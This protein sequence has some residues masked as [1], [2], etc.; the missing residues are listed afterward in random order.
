MTP[1]P[2]RPVIHPAVWS[3]TLLML[4]A[5]PL[6][7]AQPLMH[8]TDVTV[9][10]IYERP[11]SDE[12]HVGDLGGTWQQADRFGIETI[13]A[14]QFASRVVPRGGFHVALDDRK[15][16]VDGGGTVDGHALVTALTGGAEGR[17]FDGPRRA[18]DPRLGLLGRAGVG[19]QDGTMT[20]I[21][22]ANGPASGDLAPL[23][24]EFAVL[25][26]GRMETTFGLE[27]MAGLGTTWWFANRSTSLDIDN[28]G[29]TGATA[30]VNAEYS[31]NET[32]VRAGAGWRF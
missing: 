6:A 16:S 29:G 2:T 14:E 1:F 30:T 4:L 25:L 28:S 7:A 19:F 21:P 24:Y 20:D 26:E 22:T 10:L 23:R 11:I 9:S 15:G 18:I 32:F 13:F 31:G 5:V 27:L 17:L 8:D 3:S 12:F